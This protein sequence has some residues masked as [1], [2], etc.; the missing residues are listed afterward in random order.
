MAIASQSIA[1]SVED[2]DIAMGVALRGLLRLK[3]GRS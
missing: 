2:E 3:A 1:V